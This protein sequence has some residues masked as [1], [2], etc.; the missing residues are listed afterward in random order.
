MGRTA[1]IAFADGCPRAQFDTTLVCE[2]LK[3]NGWTL[4]EAVEEADMVVVTTCAVEQRAEDRSFALLQA[5]DD[6]RKAGSL[7]VVTGCMAGIL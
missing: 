3:A 7:L 1:C 5:A 6:R 2:Y 4:T